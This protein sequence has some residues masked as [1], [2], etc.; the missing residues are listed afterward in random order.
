ME[1]ETT[2]ELLDLYKTLIDKD[3]NILDAE[4]FDEWWEE[5]KNREPFFQIINED[6]EESLPAV[7][8]KVADLEEEVKKLKRHKHET[9][10]GDVLIRI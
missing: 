9:N 5:I 2:T 10:S 1:N 7:V 4:K 8:R 6:W 3:G